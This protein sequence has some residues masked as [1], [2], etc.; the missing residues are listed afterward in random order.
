[1][2][3]D[4]IAW[5]DELLKVA[6]RLEAKT[7][8]KRWT[9]RTG[10]LIERDFVVSAYAMRKLFASGSVPDEPGRQEFPVR[11]FDRIGDSY[12]FDN[13]RRA[14]LSVLDLCHEIT[15]SVDFEFCCGETA[16]LFDGVYV[17]SDRDKN[18][19]LYLILASDYIALCSDVAVW[20]SDVS[21]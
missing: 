5:K 4:A 10:Y 2:S 13:G 16:D 14:M 12:D 9:E 6:D 21:V 19:Y 8:Q 3:D 18:E 1:V 7:K 20:I 15:Y 11:R 17:S